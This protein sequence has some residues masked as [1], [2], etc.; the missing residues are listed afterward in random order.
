MCG[1][2]CIHYPHLYGNNYHNPHTRMISKSVFACNE[3]ICHT[4]LEF[5]NHYKFY[6]GPI[7]NTTLS[8]T[9][10]FAII[11]FIVIG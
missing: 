11:F 5:K 3:K 7:N 2:F 4:W 10:I 1:G 9:T 6:I 8:C